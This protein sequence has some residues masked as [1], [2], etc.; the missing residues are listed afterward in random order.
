MHFYRFV[1]VLSSFCFGLA[2]A[3]DFLKGLPFAQAGNLEVKVGLSE[4]F[5]S[6]VMATMARSQEQINNNTDT[7]FA[8]LAKSIP[9]LWPTMQEWG[10]VS[11]RAL[12]PVQKQIIAGTLAAVAGTAIVH[13]TEA[14][15]Q[16]YIK[17]YFFQ[18]R[19]IS[20]RSSF[21]ERL[22]NRFAQQKTSLESI[23][24][25]M[26]IDD[27]NKEDL[28]YLIH[29]TSNLK[30]NGGNYENAIFYGPPGTGKTLS[31]KLIAQQCGMDYVIIPAAN[32]SQFLADQTIVEELNSLFDMAES[33]S[34]G[35]IMFFDEA[36]TFLSKREEM[37]AQA[38]HALN[39]FLARTGTASSKFMVM[40]ATNRP[41]V[42]DPA[43]LSRFGLTIHFDVPTREA[44]LDIIRMYIDREFFKNPKDV[45]DSGLLK[46]VKVLEN[47]ADS[48]KGCSGRDISKCIA[49]I[50][51]RV[52]ATQTL[53][54][55]SNSIDRAVKQVT[56]KLKG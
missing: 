31:A 22:K 33:S 36:E 3:V 50:R 13:L 30:K 40:C 14:A 28:Q 34:N 44:R 42:L 2:Q 29:T 23:G 55:T 56:Q 35:L 20:E 45:I 25:S 49:A 21:F 47:L 15:A 5:A 24:R 4:S 1:L 16:K 17:K 8:Q 53:V 9:Q 54:V 10:N 7:F 12:A 26:I 18:P 52:L 38:Q 41:E 43:V 39:L 6:D 48:L 32:I 11:A 19:L 46:N 51:Q 27:R 37:S